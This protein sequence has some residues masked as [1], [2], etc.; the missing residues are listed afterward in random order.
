MP[1]LCIEKVGPIRFIDIA[2][3][4]VNVIIGPQSSGKSTINKIACYCAWVEKKCSLD[5]SFDFFTK[6][7]VFL[8]N[9]IIFHKLDG[10]I[11]G[12]SKIS[13]KSDVIEFSL[14]KNEVSFK[15]IEQYKYIRTKIS[16]IPAERNVVSIITGWSEVNLPDNNIRNFMTD[17]NNARKYHSD[18]NK[19]TIESLGFSFYYDADQNIDYVQLA[20][21]KSI[22]LLNGSSGQQSV[23]PLV[24]LIEYFTKSIY[25]ESE[26]A[27][28]SI[29]NQEKISSLYPNLFAKHITDS[30]TK[31]QTQKI[32]M[33]TDVMKTFHDEILKPEITEDNV[34]MSD[35]GIEILRE[36]M[37]SLHHYAVNQHS[38]LF[39][40]EPE[41]NLF[42][43]T[44]RTLLYYILN[45]IKDE[46]RNHSLFLT[47][48]SPYILYAL[49]NSMMGWIVKDAIPENMIEQ[50]ESYKSWINPKDVSAWQIE[51]GELISIQDK[52]TKTIGKHYFNAAMNESMDEYYI[53]LKYLKPEML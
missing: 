23:I 18:E 3:N 2:L 53:M 17:W 20:N 47:T 38:N 34:V 31:E 29:A 39:I 24:L 6:D 37:T 10:Y 44:Q 36:T 30:L 41:S 48:H 16:Y 1:H 21:D 42:P 8:K 52:R 28:S 35:Q 27:Q 45:E 9:L 7:D 40:E 14:N 4:K 12:D 49:N 43:A 51:N 33:S 26:I 32:L 19:L 13:Y 46:T 11:D 15:W 5:Q 50:L 22:K 25:E